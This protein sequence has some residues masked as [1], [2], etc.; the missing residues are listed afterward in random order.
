MRCMVTGGAGFIG[1]ELASALRAD[2]HHVMTLDVVPAQPSEDA[3]VCDLGQWSDLLAAFV[4]AKPDVVFH[5]G[6]MISTLAEANPQQ[7]YRVNI[8]GTFNLLELSRQLGVK[9]FVYSSTVAVYGRAV[10]SPVGDDAPQFPTTMYGATKVACEQLGVYYHR[11]YGF[12][13]RGL[14]LPTI[15][16]PTR[17]AVG[18]GAFATQILLQP[19]L[20]NPYTAPVEPDTRVALL[21]I[22][23]AVNSLKDFAQAPD[24]ALRR[25]V[26]NIRGLSVTPAELVAALRKVV[27]GARVDFKTD[28]SIQ[29]IVGSWPILDQSNAE[30]DW[31]WRERYDIDRF[32]S[33]F[34]AD[35]IENARSKEPAT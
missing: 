21:Y 3:L 18:A 20:G 15:T 25:R 9:T 7:A 33:D 34:V 14:R 24:N 31:G 12:D 13:F 17:K 30:K 8:D 2:G 19:A 32:A 10:Q 29:A 26:Y 35:A 1:R 22:K 16:G 23:D 4:K 11:K 5:L 27:P 28:P 6:A